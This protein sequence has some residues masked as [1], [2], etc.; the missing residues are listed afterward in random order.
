MDSVDISQ[1]CSTCQGVEADVEEKRIHLV[2]FYCL[3]NVSCLLHCYWVS[4]IPRFNTY[5]QFTCVPFLFAFFYYVI[6]RDILKLNFIGTTKG[7]RVCIEITN[8]LRC[9]LC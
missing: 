3:P 6:F 4:R 1:P 9:E 2:P 5:R 7:K 8:D